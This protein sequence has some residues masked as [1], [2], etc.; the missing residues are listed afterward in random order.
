MFSKSLLYQWQ[1]VLEGH[2][3][4]SEATHALEKTFYPYNYGQG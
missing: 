1:S 4:L 2:V 3:Y